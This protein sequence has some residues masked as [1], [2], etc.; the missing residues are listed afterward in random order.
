MSVE[1]LKTGV[2]YIGSCR[3]ESCISVR[4]ACFVVIKIMVVS[5]KMVQQKVSSV[6]VC[7]NFFWEKDRAVRYKT[8]L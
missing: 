6:L 1:L 8:S 4:I 3:I 5:M 2:A 7:N